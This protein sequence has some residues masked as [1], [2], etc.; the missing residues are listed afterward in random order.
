MEPEGQLL[1]LQQSA[2]C[3]CPEPDQSSPWPQSHFLNT[4]LDIIH[5]IHTWIFQVVPLPQFFPPKPSTHPSSPPYVL[6]APP[7]SFFSVWSPG[8]Y[9]VR[10]AKH[11]KFLWVFSDWG[12]I[13]WHKAVFWTTVTCTGVNVANNYKV[14]RSLIYA[15]ESA[16]DPCWKWR[17]TD[18]KSDHSVHGHVVYA[19]TWSNYLNFFLISCLSK[20]NTST[21]M[22]CDKV[23]CGA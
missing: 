4:H 15:I 9:L 20:T 10:F 13:S 2:T 8:K 18:S 6:H 23:H 16:T 14:G 11:Q 19:H 7:I 22:E 17:W 5:P 12:S 3:P 1:R 21:I